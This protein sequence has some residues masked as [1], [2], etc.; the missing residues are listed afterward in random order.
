[1]VVERLKVSWLI[2][3]GGIKREI[4]VS[5]FGVSFW[6]EFMERVYGGH[7]LQ[8][9]FCGALFAVH[10]LQRIESDEYIMGKNSDL[11]RKHVRYPR[12][13]MFEGWTN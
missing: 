7:F 12:Q 3:I 5:V 13:S 4:L 10:F 1:M 11:V 9:T 2:F 8:C 6:R